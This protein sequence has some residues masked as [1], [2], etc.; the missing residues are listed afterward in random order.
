MSEVKT[1]S[2]Q[3]PPLPLPKRSL[4]ECSVCGRTCASKCSLLLQWRNKHRFF[5]NPQLFVLQS[6]F[7]Q[8]KRNL[9]V[10]EREMHK[11][12]ESVHKKS[13]SSIYW[14]ED[15]RIV[16]FSMLYDVSVFV[17]TY[18]TMCH[19]LICGNV[20][21]AQFGH[22]QTVPGL[23]RK[24]KQSFDKCFIDLIQRTSWLMLSLV[25]VFTSKFT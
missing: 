21:C 19:M 7:G 22:V 1:Q 4:V 25:F 6:H 9:S 11:A 23:A 8:K 17:A 24:R 16:L 12:V 20:P 10:Y 18:R 5:C 15:G 2:H 13:V 14:M 3:D